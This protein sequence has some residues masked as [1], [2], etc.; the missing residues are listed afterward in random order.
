MGRTCSTHV[1][2]ETCKQDVKRREH[3]EWIHLAQ[4]REQW[5]L[6]VNRVMDFGFHV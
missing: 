1:K 5:R 6:V 4:D 2:D 3:L